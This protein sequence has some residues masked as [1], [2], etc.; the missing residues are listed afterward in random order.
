MGW[1]LFK[2][3]KEEEA[4]PYLE[5][6]EANLESPDPTILDHLGDA[7]Q[8]LDRRDKAADAFKRSL[9]LEFNEK[10]FQKWRRLTDKQ[11]I[12]S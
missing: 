7:Y 10:V 6:A 12:Q 11:D 4:L 8:A 2:Q 9:E 1:V 3:G 5:K